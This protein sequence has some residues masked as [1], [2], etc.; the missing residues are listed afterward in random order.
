MVVCQDIST[1]I[2]A[3][4]HSDLAFHGPTLGETELTMRAFL[5][6]AA[7]PHHWSKTF[8]SCDTQAARRTHAPITMNRKT[9]E[10]SLQVCARGHVVVTENVITS[11]YCTMQLVYRHS[12][13]DH[14]IHGHRMIPSVEGLPCQLGLVN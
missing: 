14:L 2:A 7:A 1:N 11:C 9:Y 4:F 6:T 13:E 3:C 12:G 10:L 5:P 8:K